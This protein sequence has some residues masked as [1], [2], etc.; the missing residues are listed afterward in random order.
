MMKSI[1]EDKKLKEIL[2]NHINSTQGWISKGSMYYLAEQEEYSPEYCGR[3]LRKLAE[4]EL[5]QVSYYTGK[6]KQK[7][8]K[9][10]KLGE[11][12]VKPKVPTIKIVFIN[13][14]PIAKY[15]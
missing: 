15:V 1:D 10:A 5:I 4:K 6:R 14:S 13:G 7:L 9:Y 8:A 12:M 2:L 3:E 11:E